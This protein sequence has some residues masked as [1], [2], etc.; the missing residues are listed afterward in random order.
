MNLA[1]E[2]PSVKQTI[3]RVDA[4]WHDFIHAIQALPPQQ[5]EEKL[6]EHAWT[7][8]QMLAHLALWHDLTTD[9]LGRFLETGRPVAL[10][11]DEEAINARA[12]RGAEGRTSGEV[13]LVLQESFR[14]LRRQ[15]AQLTD[16]HLAAG[17]AWAART[18]AGNTYGHYQEH[19]ADVTRR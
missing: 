18:I 3:A 4:G 16:E 13:L 15:I 10:E 14:R 17:D 7:R 8:K 9:R 6:G 12:A 19:A 11:D 5:L 2:Q 1:T